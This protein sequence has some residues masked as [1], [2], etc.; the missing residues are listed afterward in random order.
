MREKWGGGGDE[1]H[2]GHGGTGVNGR[3]GGVRRQI[4]EDRGGHRGN[5]RR[6]ETGFKSTIAN[7]GG[8]GNGVG[9][10]QW[11]NVIREPVNF[12]KLSV[13]ITFPRILLPTCTV[14][15]PQYCFE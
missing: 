10:N 14:E 3:G 15:L 4:R 1:K 11:T 13:H 6:G 9:G 12:I 7:I 2:G 8:G 5:F